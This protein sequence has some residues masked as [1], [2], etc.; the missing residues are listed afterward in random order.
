[1][2]AD[3]L[4]LMELECSAVERMKFDGLVEGGVD[5]EKNKDVV[6][7]SVLTNKGRHLGS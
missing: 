1:M 2:A 4:T 5:V 3:N 7:L 6:C